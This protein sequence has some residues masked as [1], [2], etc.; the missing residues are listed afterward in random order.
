M[1]ENWQQ[2][3]ESLSLEERVIFLGEV[4]DEQL[5]LYYHA[6][7]LFVLPACERSEAFGTVQLEAMAAAQPNVFV[8]TSEMTPFSTRAVSLMVSPQAGL[9]TVAR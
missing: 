7:D 8:R 6:C 2:L 1:L 4:E 5:P 3:S 9:R